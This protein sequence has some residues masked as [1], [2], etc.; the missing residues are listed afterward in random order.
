MFENETEKAILEAMK[1]I[2]PDLV[3][4]DMAA[5]DIFKAL[6]RLEQG[7]GGKLQFTKGWWQE[8]GDIMVMA[9]DIDVTE[10]LTGGALQL[11]ITPLGEIFTN[12]PLH[13]WAHDEGAEVRMAALHR[14]LDADGVTEERKAEIFSDPE[15]VAGMAEDARGMEIKKEDDELGRKDT[16]AALTDLARRAALQGLISSADAA[17]FADKAAEDSPAQQA[18]AEGLRQGLRARE[19]EKIMLSGLTNPLVRGFALLQRLSN[20]RIHVKPILEDDCSMV[21]FEIN[22]AHYEMLVTVRSDGTMTFITDGGHYTNYDALDRQQALEPLKDVAKIA[23]FAGVLSSVPAA[24]DDA[25]EEEKVIHAGIKNAL[26]EIRLA[27]EAAAPLIE[28]LSQLRDLSK[29]K[30]DFDFQRT[31]G[32]SDIEIRVNPEKDGLQ[33]VMK[34]SAGGMVS[35]G[36]TEDGYK[37]IVD[38]TKE[39]TV[40]R[41]LSDITTAAVMWR[42][43]PLTDGAQDMGSLLL[44]A[45]ENE[46][47][48]APSETAAQKGLREGMNG[49][50][51]IITRTLMAAEGI[52]NGLKFI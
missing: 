27:E 5:R 43:V 31:E 7:S 18:V 10:K 50:A 30:F 8:S 14:H 16:A 32:S 37:E 38:G 25:S 47:A 35:C 6:Q 49:A 40:S 20:N 4:G 1:N 46:E 11:K 51:K 13:P 19:V 33:P 2:A 17:A 21:D 26:E 24:G 44:S 36:N 48:D 12:V 52:N 34:V 22:G 42:E 39:E 29:G 28:G 45:L 15:T 23:L 9:S 3:R 41:I